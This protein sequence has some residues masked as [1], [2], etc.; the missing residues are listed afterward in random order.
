MGLVGYLVE[1][2]EICGVLRSKLLQSFS[3]FL[4]R[5]GTVLGECFFY[6][7]YFKVNGCCCVLDFGGTHWNLCGEKCNCYVHDS[8]YKQDLRMFEATTAKRNEYY[9]LVE[10][11]FLLFKI[12]KML[13]LEIIEFR[14]FFLI[15]WLNYTTINF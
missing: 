7:S 4:W 10:L 1:I 14:T 3:I 5:F 9:Y 2:E 15:Y 11:N 13:N 8:E 12:L 6:I